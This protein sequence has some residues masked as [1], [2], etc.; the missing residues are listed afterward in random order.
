MFSVLVQFLPF[1][2]ISSHNFKSK[3]SNFN[4][5]LTCSRLLPL[6]KHPP[7]RAPRGSCQENRGSDPRADSLKRGS[8]SIGLRSMV[9]GEAM[10]VQT[11]EK[12]PTSGIRQR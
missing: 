12:N 7:Y 9:A 8:V 6:Q 5:Y 2:L 1:E 11:T 10:E 3:K 4:K